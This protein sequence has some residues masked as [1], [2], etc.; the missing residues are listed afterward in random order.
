MKLPTIRLS[1]RNQI[2]LFLLGLGGVLFVFWHYGIRDISRQRAQ[3][4]SDRRAL[5]RSG[6]ATQTREALEATVD[7]E[8]QVRARLAQEWD[9]ITDRLATFA[10]QSALAQSHVL[11]ID[12]KVELHHT[13]SRLDRKAALL[14]I[15]LSAKELG[16]SE[17]VFSTDEPRKLMIQLRSVE[18]L[19][20]MALD[21]RIRNLVKVRPQEP[22]EHYR[23]TDDK[24]IFEEYPVEVEFDVDFANFYDLF[25]VVFDEG[26]VFVFRNIRI[27]SGATTEAPLR[28][29]AVLSALLFDVESE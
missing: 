24:L 7:H 25:R 13:R 3:N 14:G 18:K 17:E 29:T 15:S 2:V 27:V 26:T 6:F 16:M 10:N 21:R 19:V 23:P 5:E 9:E 11:R 22:I 12:Y 4:A 8:N 28:V 20:D 1:E